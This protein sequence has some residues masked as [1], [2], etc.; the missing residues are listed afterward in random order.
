MCPILFSGV[1]ISGFIASKSLV[2]T[3]L[4]AREMR[5]SLLA[6]TLPLILGGVVVPSQSSSAQP[7]PPTFEDAGIPPTVPGGSRG[8]LGDCPAGQDT[9]HPDILPLLPTG[10][11]GA[12]TTAATPKIWVYLPFGMESN[13]DAKL[14]VHRV[15]VDAQ[16]QPQVGEIV[17]RAWVDIY[18]S[19]PGIHQ[20]A[21]PLSAENFPPEAVMLT[22]SPNAES[23]ERSSAYAWTLEIFCNASGGNPA[24]VRGTIRR[25]EGDIASDSEGQLQTPEGLSQAYA[26]RGIWYD[27][28]TVLGEA[29][30]VDPNN[31]EYEAAWQELLGYSTVGLEAIANE[32]LANCCPP[33]AE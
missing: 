6:L 2:F 1:T 8:D 5:R 14:L 15:E 3:S 29:R 10:F 21:L 12:W 33:S 17:D 26:D 24:T 23:T 32:P 31:A 28:L 7:P 27:A 20:F 22:S 11:G 25:G 18:P 4:V 13:Y 16:G 30:L 9:L 19:Q